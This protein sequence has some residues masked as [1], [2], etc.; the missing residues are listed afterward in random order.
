MSDDKTS[1]RDTVV[2]YLHKYPDFLSENPEVLEILEIPHKSGAAVSLIE[3][4]V[5]QLRA[6]NEDLNQQ[7]RYLIRVAT[8]NEQLMS[9]L[10]KLTLELIL[11]ESRSEFFTH[12]GDALLNDFNTDILQIC[13]FD[14]ELADDAGEDVMNIAVDDPRMELFRATLEK[15]EIFCGRMSMERMDFLF[16][17]KARWVQS[18]ALMPLGKNGLFGLM[19]IGSSDQNRFFP[20]MGTLFLDLLTD[21]IS[22]NLSKAQPQE[23]RRTA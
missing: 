8:E 21:V 12:L 13:L 23:Q 7:L 4:Q 16:G 14:P 3:R 17:S 5:D 22:T 19:A 1:L 10:H 15:G 6:A 2:D 20:G 9:R 18:M 11:I